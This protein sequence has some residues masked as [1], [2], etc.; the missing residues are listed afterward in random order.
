MFNKILP[1]LIKADKE[2]R[3]ESTVRMLIGVYDQ[4]E[5]NDEATALRKVLET[6]K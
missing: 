2:E 1:F 4:L 3:S 5:K 6:L